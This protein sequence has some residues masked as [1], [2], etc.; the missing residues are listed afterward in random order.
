M[1]KLT[2]KTVALATLL[3][4]LLGACGLKTTPTPSPTPTP[5]PHTPPEAVPAVVVQR[6]PERGEELPPDGAIELI[7]DRPM[8]RASVEAAFRLSPEVGG[9][10]EWADARTVRFKPA[11]DLKRDAEYQATVGTEAQATDGNPL[12]EAYR[13]RFRTVGYLEVAQVIPAADAEDVEAKSTVT[14][15]FNRPV[16]PLTAV[17]DP[18]TADLPQPIEFDPPVEGSG[19][20]LNTSIYVFTPA[21]S[22]A[23]GTTYT[24]RIAAG[25][26]D[27]TGGVLA[28]DFEWSFS[29]QPPQVV[30]TSPH[31][32]AELVAVE[33]T[34]QVTFNMPV[35]PAS[36]KTAFHLQAGREDVPG[37]ATVDGAT[38]VFTATHRLAF[39]TAY[40]A[41]VDAGVQGA[42][43]GQGMRDAY[44]WRFTTVP[45]P[46]IV[47]TR[48]YDGQQDAWPHT[49]FEITFNAPIDPVTVM[50]N[51]K[52][53]PPIS[54]TQVYTHFRAWDNTFVFGFGARPSIDYEVHIGPDIADPYGNTTGQEMS[55]RFRTAD[56]SPWVQIYVPGM[57]GTS[58][59]HQPARVVIGHLNTTRLDLSLHRL[60]MGSSSARSETGGN[61]A[62]PAIPSASGL[63]RSQPRSTRWDTQRWT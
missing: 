31:E 23:G 28:E 29:T 13:F 19:E 3:S 39:D 41:R 21:T 35:D 45:L 10:F 33:P 48:P 60:D 36:A 22:L 9:D 61:T 56:L 43:G 38:L 54:P 6:T 24:A 40:T 25:L 12:G 20:W 37:T 46:R 8:D 15:I 4:V 53:S 5:L 52:M 42:E 34:V 7:F 26:T 55:V 32:E 63:Y 27:T 30:W 58:D 51:L 62:S 1:R 14:V 50:P 18:A 59:A 57:A 16:V 49:D 11:R 2:F 17:S 47:S 44:E